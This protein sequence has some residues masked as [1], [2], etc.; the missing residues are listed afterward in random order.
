MVQVT[1]ERITDAALQVVADKGYDALTV[2][3]ITKVLGTSP[4]SVYAHIVNMADVDDL[5]VGRLCSRIVLPEPDPENRR[6]QIHDVCAQLRDQY[7]RYPGSSRA[8]LAL[9]A[10]NPETLRVSEGM[11]AILLA[12]GIEARTAAWAIDALALY[13]AGYALE[14]SM[15]QRRR[16]HP[17]DTWVESREEL[18]RRFRAL[19]K[20][21]C[22]N[23]RR[24]ADHDLRRRPSALRL[25]S[26]TA[27]RQPAD[28]PDHG[29]TRT[30]A[31]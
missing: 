29:A 8:A 28:G 5:L 30:A 27:H 20:A 16:K 13:V 11:L 18:L 7:L 1:V 25:R 6:E 21:T 31:H 23:T 10:T 26:R 19:S 2:R 22:P 14:A 15:V 12:G 17:D 24:H 3:A 4:S 9:V